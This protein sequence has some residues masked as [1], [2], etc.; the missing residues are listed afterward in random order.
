[1]KLKIKE[2]K[3]IELDIEESKLLI[4]LLNYC[5]HRAEK[6]ETPVSKFAD[7]IREFRKELKIIK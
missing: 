5:Y 3:I 6:H 2:V 4:E 7:Q 1:M